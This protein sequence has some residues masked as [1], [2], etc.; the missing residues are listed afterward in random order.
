MLPWSSGSP[1]N[2]SGQR[3]LCLLVHAATLNPNSRWGAHLSCLER[4]PKEPLQWWRR[5][6]SLKQLLRGH[7]GPQPVFRLPSRSLSG[8]DSGGLRGVMG[9]DSPVIW[10]LALRNIYQ[11]IEWLGLQGWE[12]AAP[13]DVSSHCHVPVSSPLPSCPDSEKWKSSGGTA[14]VK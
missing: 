10:C 9:S 3:G 11:G 8:G 2:P 4:K 6:F 7:Q 14:W 12:V 5:V 1:G 13:C